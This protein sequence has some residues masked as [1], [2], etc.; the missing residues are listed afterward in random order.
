MTS[1]HLASTSYIADG[2]DEVDE[3]ESRREKWRNRAMEQS[4]VY[5]AYLSDREVIA[6][7]ISIKHHDVDQT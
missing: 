5:L 6:H 2:F 1:R 3:I 7:I 4:S